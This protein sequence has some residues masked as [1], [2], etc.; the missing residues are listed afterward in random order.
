M[1]APARHATPYA[2]FLLGLT[3]ALLATNM[4]VSRLAAGWISPFSLTFWRWL[5]TALMMA[6]L[7]LPLLHRHA[8]V[9][10]QEWRSVLL[11]G[12]IGMT[13]C[14]AS[15]YLA[16]QT[17]TTANIALLYAASPVLMTLLARIFLR[18]SLDWRRTAGI[19]LCLLG[20]VVIVARGKPESL[21]MLRFTPGD[22]WALL[23]SV[24]WA[25]FS[26]L[27]VWIPSRL[28]VHV[29]ITAMGFAGALV[30]APFALGEHAAG[31]GFPVSG[32][33]LA[34]LAFTVL[35]TSYGSYT[36]YAKLQHLSSVSFAGMATYVAPLWAALYGWLFMHERLQGYH[37]IGAALVLPGIWLARSVPL[38]EEEPPIP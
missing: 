1:T 35:V 28:P 21:A 5:L 29:R 15:S 16:G 17:T 20:L 10:A 8:R 19:V 18:E 7:A 30:A 23:G 4:L 31:G 3:P 38:A 13:L 34:L 36:L 9:L 25:V 37:F 12:S 11:L 24:G 2:W 26:F 27:Q 6:A 14:G 22:F 32:S 33:S